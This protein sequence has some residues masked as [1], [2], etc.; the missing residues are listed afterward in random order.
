MLKSKKLENYMKYLTWWVGYAK[1][2]LKYRC[3]I[4]YLTYTSVESLWDG[5]AGHVQASRY[6]V[7][8]SLSFHIWGNLSEHS[9]RKNWENSC[10]ESIEGDFDQQW[11]QNH[12]IWL[13]PDFEGEKTRK[14]QSKRRNNKNRA[15]RNIKN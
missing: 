12:I 9:L 10:S 8:N 15:S 14:F 3:Y 6:I 1:L 4:G 5:Y 13:L 11:G 7:G 2:I